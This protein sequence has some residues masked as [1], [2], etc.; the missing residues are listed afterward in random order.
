MSNQTVTAKFFEVQQKKRYNFTLIELLVVIAIIAIL[1]SMLLPALNKA[2]ITANRSKCLGNVKQLQQGITLYAGDYNDQCPTQKPASAS[3]SYNDNAWMWHLY[4]SYNIGP[5]VFICPGNP[6]NTDKDNAANYVAGI[7]SPIAGQIV[8]WG[9][10]GSRNSYGFNQRLLLLS[11]E[12]IP[13]IPLPGGKLG[14]VKHPSLMIMIVEDAFP[15]MTEGVSDYS[16]RV[17]SRFPGNNY[18]KRDHS[19]SGVNFGM[20]D[21][22]ATGINYPGNSADISFMPEAAEK[23]PTSIVWAK[24]WGAP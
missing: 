22:H 3:P 19:G 11:Q 20:V 18:S 4:Y 12:W 24:L 9:E 8:G 15:M 13:A 2:R 23:Y 10:D 21:G 16:R 14:K 5:K 7:G 1:A 6:R 17:L